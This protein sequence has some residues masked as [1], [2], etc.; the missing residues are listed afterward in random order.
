MLVVVP[1]YERCEMTLVVVP[2][3]VLNSSAERSLWLLFPF[4]DLGYHQVYH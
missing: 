2:T 1:T 3:L 4:Y